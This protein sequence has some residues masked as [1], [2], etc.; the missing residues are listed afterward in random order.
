MPG[1]VDRDRV[2][3]E[4]GKGEI[5]EGGVGVRIGAHASRSGGVQVTNGRNR[6]STAVE[7]FFGPVTA[8]PVFE[9]A[10]V[11]V[12]VADVRKGH[13]MC[14]PGPLHGKSV[15]LHRSGP[16]FRGTQHD[17]RPH[18]SVTAAG[19]PCLLLDLGDPIETAIERVGEAPVHVVG[20]V[21]GDDDRFVSVSTKQ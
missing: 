1:S 9:D 2:V 11:L 4:G 20:F 19:L 12:V 6:C 8:H 5:T 7:Q 10:S 3:A 15:D 13:L 17:H 18:G 14:P 21:T 16:A